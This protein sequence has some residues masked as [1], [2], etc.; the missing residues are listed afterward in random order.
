MQTV[1]ELTEVTKRY[2]RVVA[3]DGLNLSIRSRRSWFLS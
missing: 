1:A 2:G 3:L